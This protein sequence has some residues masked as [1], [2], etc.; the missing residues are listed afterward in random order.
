MISLEKL[1][2]ASLPVILSTKQ[3]FANIVHEVFF[4]YKTT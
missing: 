3:S 1:K 4:K 2:L